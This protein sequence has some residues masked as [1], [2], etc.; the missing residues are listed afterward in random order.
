MRAY[1]EGSLP[2]H[3][4]ACVG[5]LPQHRQFAAYAVRLLLSHGAEPFSRCVSRCYTQH[6]EPRQGSICP[7]H[8]CLGGSD[9]RKTVTSQMLHR[10]TDEGRTALHWAAAAGLTDVAEALLADPAPEPS[11]QK[12]AAEPT[13]NGAAA[14]SVSAE[15]MAV[16][17]VTVVGT[18]SATGAVTAAEVVHVAAA[19]VVAP[20]PPLVELQDRLGSTPLHLAA[21]GSY[22]GVLA[23]LLAGAPQGDVGAGCKSCAPS[24]TVSLSHNNAYGC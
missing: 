5:A 14:A 4:A 9:L 3:I 12:A 21:R 24:S 19:P 23:L 17:S 15:G 22:P 16:S 2:I 10:R 13:A 6:D 1:C 20:P 11:P 8:G 18:A 7:W